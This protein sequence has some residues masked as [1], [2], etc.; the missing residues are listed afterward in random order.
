MSLY[1]TELMMSTEARAVCRLQRFSFSSQES[2]KWLSDH[3]YTEPRTMSL[4][5]VRFENRWS[6][7]TAHVWF[8][9]QWLSSM[10]DTARLKQASSSGQLILC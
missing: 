2:V 1:E 7:D 8:S 9:K 6:E 5:H 4:G 10:T 3:Q